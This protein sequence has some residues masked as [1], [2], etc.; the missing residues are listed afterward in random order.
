MVS[1]QPLPPRLPESRQHR[2]LDRLLEV[3]GAI[4]W[5][6][7]LATG[8]CESLGLAQEPVFGWPQEHWRKQ[9]FWGA[10]VHPEDQPAFLKFLLN[11]DQP[12]GVRKFEF[13]LRNPEGDEHWVRVAGGVE[14][15]PGR[16]RV[17]GFLSDIHAHKR[18]EENALRASQK[19][20]DLLLREIH[21]RVKNKRP[22]SAP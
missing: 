8:R 13:R 2:Y 10:V 12:S 20:K 7:D 16:A 9:A 1:D 18:A 17:M 22:S 6:L 5:E 19:G 14:P 21:H 11:M 15:G 4:P 3:T